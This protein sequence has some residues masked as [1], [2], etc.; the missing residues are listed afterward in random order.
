V[1]AIAAVRSPS[2]CRVV[3]LVLAIAVVGDYERVPP[4]EEREGLAETAAVHADVAPPPE[5]LRRQVRDPGR[6]RQ[7]CRMIE[8]RLEVQRLAA[9][10]LDHDAGAGLAEARVCTGEQGGEGVEGARQQLRLARHR[11]VGRE[12]LCRVPAHR[13]RQVESLVGAAH[14]H[15][16]V[17]VERGD[18]RPR[19]ITEDGAREGEGQPGRQEAQPGE[20]LGRRWGAL[21]EREVGQVQ[22][23]HQVF[24]TPVIV[25][26]PVGSALE[27]RACHDRVTAALP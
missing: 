1:L 9:A 25:V 5:R 13:R 3:R 10:H 27:E 18:V 6:R 19:V 14:L 2:A 24:R 8:E 16:A 7:P 26:G 20:Q 22:A 4:F 21:E 12:A 17:P 11:H 15:E 23:R